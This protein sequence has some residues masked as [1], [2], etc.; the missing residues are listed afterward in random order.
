M[1]Y[2]WRKNYNLQSQAADDEV[3]GSA[4]PTTALEYP[5]CISPS[6][7]RSTQALRSLL[8]FQ[9]RAT[10]NPGNGEAVDMPASSPITL[11]LRKTISVVFA[12]E[13]GVALSQNGASSATGEHRPLPGF[14]L[15]DC[16]YVWEEAHRN[17]QTMHL[18]DCFVKI[19]Q[20][21][22]SHLRSDTL[23]EKEKST[24]VNFLCDSGAIQLQVTTSK[25]PSPDEGNLERHGERVC[26]HNDGTYSMV[27]FGD[28]EDADDGDANLTTVQSERRCFG[29]GE[30]QETVCDHKKYKKE[31]LTKKSSEKLNTS[32]TF[33]SVEV[34]EDYVE[35]RELQESRVGNSDLCESIR[36]AKHCFSSRRRE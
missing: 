9:L 13:G 14:S 11:S 20:Q 6:R 23:S 17:N 8:S 16:S 10:S 15:Q 28:P 3:V 35:G 29:Q 5:S 30:H 2:L 33:A 19:T 4:P 22:I 34:T 24:L 7:Q 25:L 12:S 32:A 1:F 18:S 21:M 36:I 27:E 26:D 31:K